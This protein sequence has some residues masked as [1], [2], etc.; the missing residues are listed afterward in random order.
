MSTNVKSLFRCEWNA[1]YIDSDESEKYI[2]STKKTLRRN[3]RHKT[4]QGLKTYARG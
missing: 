2:K 3:E 1:N 4:R